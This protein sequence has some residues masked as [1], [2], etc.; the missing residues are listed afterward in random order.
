MERLHLRRQEEDVAR[1]PFESIPR[2]RSYSRKLD[3]SLT[4]RMSLLVG[5]KEIEEILQFAFIPLDTHTH[6]S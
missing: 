3:K 5:L 1:D 4:S 2:T 6:T